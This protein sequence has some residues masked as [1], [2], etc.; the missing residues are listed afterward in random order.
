MAE[1]WAYSLEGQPGWAPSSRW[2]TRVTTA[3]I[4]IFKKQALI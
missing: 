4:L 2:T 1:P 3:P